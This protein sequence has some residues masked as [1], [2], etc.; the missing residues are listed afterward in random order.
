MSEK[1]RKPLNTLQRAINKP[2]IV[3]LKGDLEYRGKMSNVDAYMNVIL[4]DAE[5]YAAGSLS[6]NFGKVVIRGN[7][8]IFIKIQPDIRVI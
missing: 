4:T 2:V 5:E 8:I 3:S 7:N 6:A 1:T